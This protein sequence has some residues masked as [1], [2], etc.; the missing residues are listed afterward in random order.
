MALGL[1][2]SSSRFHTNDRGWYFQNLHQLTNKLDLFRLPEKNATSIMVSIGSIPLITE[3]SPR[4]GWSQPHL[5]PMGWCCQCFQRF[6]RFQRFQQL[7]PEVP[8]RK[9]WGL[10]PRSRYGSQVPVGGTSTGWWFGT[11]L[12]FPY[13]GNNH[14][15]DYIIFFRGVE[16]TNQSKKDS[17]SYD[18]QHVSH[19]SFVT[20]FKY[21]LD[22]LDEPM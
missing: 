7:T 17:D 2:C 12:I 15:T 10:I 20:T 8:M 16:T 9:V 21:P 22:S 19:V 18:D 13:I 6:Q 1:A 4:P 3:V 5:T 11:F 14:P